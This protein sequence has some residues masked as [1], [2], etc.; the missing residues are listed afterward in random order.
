M[1]QVSP[2]DKDGNYPLLD[3]PTTVLPAKFVQQNPDVF[4]VVDIAA[5]WVPAKGESFWTSN[6]Y[7]DIVQLTAGDYTADIAIVRGFYFQTQQAA[8]DWLAQA[9][10]LITYPKVGD[11]LAVQA[12]QAQPVAEPPTPAK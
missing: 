11:V 12:A 3:D 8:S 7:F 6:S 1:Y 9:K 2:A 4:K 10:A 5:L